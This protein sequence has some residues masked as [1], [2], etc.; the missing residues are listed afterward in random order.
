M[1]RLSKSSSGIFPA[2]APSCFLNFG[3]WGLQKTYASFL[4]FAVQFQCM[5]MEANPTTHTTSNEDRFSLRGAAQM[6]IEWIYF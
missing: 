5:E 2:F 1:D 6:I 4:A 3:R